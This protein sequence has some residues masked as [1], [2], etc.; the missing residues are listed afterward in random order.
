MKVSVAQAAKIL[1]RNHTFVRIGLQRGKLP[2]GI[3]LETNKGR[4]TY[5]IRSHLLSQYTGI[6]EKDII[7]MITNEK[8]SVG[9]K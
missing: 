1:E 9:H 2:I 3:A 8:I 5:D 4:Y 7:A 6:P